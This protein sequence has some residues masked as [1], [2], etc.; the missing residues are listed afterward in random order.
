MGE[1]RRRIKYEICKQCGGAGRIFNPST[2][3]PYVWCPL[4][5]GEGKIITEEEVE[6]EEQNETKTS[7]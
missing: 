6:Y 1:I 7:Y 4:C 3:N 2:T 5:L